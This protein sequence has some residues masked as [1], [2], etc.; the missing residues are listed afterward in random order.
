MTIKE[1]IEAL[2][3]YPEDAEVVREDIIFRI[4]SRS[5]YD[6][7]MIDV[8]KIDYDKEDNQVIIRY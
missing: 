8:D 2:S 4:G 1:L 7:T 5:I 3:Q 6:Y